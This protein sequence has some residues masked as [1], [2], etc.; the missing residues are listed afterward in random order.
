MSSAFIESLAEQARTSQ[1]VQ[2][3]Y[4]QSLSQ[5]PVDR[6]QAALRDLFAHYRGYSRFF[7]KYLAIIMD[8]LP[9]EQRAVLN[10]N[11]EEEMGLT[12][13]DELLAAGIEPEWVRGIR[14]SKLMDRF[15][16]AAGIKPLSNDADMVP[17]VIKWRN[18]LLEVCKSS[19]AAGIGALGLGTELIVADVYRPM[20]EAIKIAFP[21]MSMNDYVFFPLHISC[22]DDHAVALMELAA[23]FAETKEG[24]KELIRGMNI[25]LDGRIRF[26][27]AMNKRLIQSAIPQNESSVKSNIPKAEDAV[28]PA[29]QRNEKL[30]QNV[31][32]ICFYHLFIYA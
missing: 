26:W 29:L 9:A 19:P 16:E 25:A 15:C 22:D 8:Q 18:D 17:E 10:E 20:L 2:H 11:M 28:K 14:H 5:G 32:P 12:H 7:T 4:L 21:E 27:D 6:I 13:D 24:R 31:C 23:S 3:P 30:V 1:A